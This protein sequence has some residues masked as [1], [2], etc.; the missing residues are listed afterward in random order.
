[1]RIGPYDVVETMNESGQALS[2]RAVHSTLRREVFL[3]VLP[4]GGERER[5]RRARFEQEARALATV[6]HPAVVR[7]YEFGEWEGMLYL[8][9]EFLSGPD[10]GKLVSESGPL[11]WPTV[12][13]IADSL[14]D[15]L[16]KLHEAQ[17]IHRDIKPTNIVMG[18]T[19][20][21]LAD[22]GLARVTESPVATQSDTLLG[23]PAYMA[24]EI[25]RGVPAGPKTDLFSLGASLFEILTGER[26]FEGETFQEVL[27][28]LA[29]CDPLRQRAH[30][31]PKDA[32]NFLSCLLSKDP[33]DRPRDA[34]EARRLLLGIEERIP[35]KGVSRRYSRYAVI[36]VPVLLALTVVLLWS[37]RPSPEPR[38]SSQQV[39]VPPD[40]AV[41]TVP[42]AASDEHAELDT[43]V[44]GA[45][46][47]Q[48]TAVT[49]R[50]DAPRAERAEQSVS[51]PEQHEPLEM[52]P[53]STDKKAAD[54]AEMW[55]FCSPWGEISLD[56]V[57]VDTTPL[58]LPLRL[59]PGGHTLLL[60]HPA[61][62][63]LELPLE[64]TSGMSESLY[65]S[66]PDSTG[67]LRINTVPWANILLDGILAGTTPITEP[68]AVSPGIH[69][70]AAQN[71]F[72]GEEIRQLEV[73][74]G[75][76]VR[77][78]IQFEQALER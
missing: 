60:S 51:I 24:P 31:L 29:R 65:V 46:T 40:S 69:T 76:T 25:L 32:C 21:K 42:V 27:A 48:D 52:S 66:F 67:Y 47:E 58:S 9:S 57:V 71:P 62:P 43:A 8:A 2:Y 50:K 38:E 20:P 33:D 53:S 17:I 16:H 12:R 19:G 23:S 35:E 70:L 11:E 10:L 55:V 56:D 64:A 75:E 77:V 78:A 26:A 45:A 4:A 34:E 59:T 14:L 7:V 49:D 5:E 41:L 74:E 36:L 15:G 54:Y 22:L 18:K 73:A 6:D 63:P 28:N 44:A 1:M 72:Y 37:L 13:E 68:L 3:K 39:E 61:F 30:N